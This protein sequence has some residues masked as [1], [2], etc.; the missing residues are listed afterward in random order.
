MRDRQDSGNKKTRLHERVA[1][2]GLYRYAANVP[3][4]STLHKQ[5]RTMTAQPES[6]HCSAIWRLFTSVQSGSM[7]NCRAG[8]RRVGSKELVYA[9]PAQS[10]LTPVF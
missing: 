4:T 3:V 10:R 2:M 1:Q 5:E 7:K 6:I 9:R 8:S